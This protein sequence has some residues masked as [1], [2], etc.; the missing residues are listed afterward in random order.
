MVR[1][2]SGLPAKCEQTRR[3]TER[4]HLAH[5]RYMKR[6]IVE[7]GAKTPIRIRKEILIK[8]QC[9]WSTGFFFTDSALE[10]KLVRM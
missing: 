8:L 9:G 3:A 1:S 5:T 6:N 10:V 4:S 7:R 2:T